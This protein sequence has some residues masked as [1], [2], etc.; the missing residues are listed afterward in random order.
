MSINGI[1]TAVIGIGSMGR[2]HARIYSEISDLVAVCDQDPKKAEE[3]SKKF[4]CKSFHNVEKMIGD[5]QID[6]VSIATP[7]VKHLES[8]RECMESGIHVLVEKPIANSVKEAEEMIRFSQEKKIIFSVGMIERHNPI[9]R[10]TK[11]VLEK[12]NIGQIVT[13]SSKRVSNFP[14]RIKDVG[15]ITD[16]GVHDIDVLRYLSGGEVKRVYA[17]GGKVKHDKFEDHATIMMRFNNGIEG[18]C[19]LSWLTPMK[20]RTISITGL[21]GVADM[22]Y[23]DQEL[24]ISKSSFQE[25]DMDNLWRIPLKYDIKRMRIRNEEPLK[26]ELEDFLKS[27]EKG[28]SPLVTGYDGL[29]TLRVAKAA[30][31]SIKIGEKVDL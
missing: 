23:V 3:I 1:R 7:T 4:R 5:V 9:V 29:E 13:L 2:N 16:L 11:E 18:V 15:V 24:K 25:I 10:F 26:R 12:G 6:A 28:T 19:E 30:E 31:E 8:A 14:A 20:T 22:D 27:V 17:L 21:E